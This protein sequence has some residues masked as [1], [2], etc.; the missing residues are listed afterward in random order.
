MYEINLSNKY[1]LKKNKERAAKLRTAIWNVASPVKTNVLAYTVQEK[2]QPLSSKRDVV[3]HRTRDKR[4]K[5][6]IS[7][8]HTLNIPR[9]PESVSEGEFS[10]VPGFVKTEKENSCL[11]KKEKRKLR[12]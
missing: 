2:K 9:S 10:S 6:T 11:R 5:T 4:K 8:T 3:T 12:G 7:R 1:E